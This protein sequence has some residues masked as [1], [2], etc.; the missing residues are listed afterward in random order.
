MTSTPSANQAAAPAAAVALARTL[1]G[2]F[3]ACFWFRRA[4]APVRSVADVELIVQRLRQH[5]DR[6]AWDA[7]LELERCL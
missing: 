7:A 1:V 3:P 4:N 5:G 6:R 2:R